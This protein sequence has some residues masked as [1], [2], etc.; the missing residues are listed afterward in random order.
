MYR[1]RETGSA[2][3]AVGLFLTA[4]LAGIAIALPPSAWAVDRSAVPTPLIVNGKEASIA[5]SPWQVAL[6]GPRFKGGPSKPSDRY[7]CTGSLLADDVVVTAAHC[8]AGY[9]KSR[10]GSL[11]VI[12]GR[13]WL[14][15]A[16][17][18]EVTRVR[19]AVFALGPDGKRRY[20]ESSGSAT[21]D[22]ALL[23]LENEVTAP[24]IRLAGDSEASVW[25]PGRKVRATG[26]GI[27]R[28]NTA[29]VSNRLR[30][31]G[32]VILPDSVCRRDNGSGYRPKTMV[33]LGGSAGNSSTCGGDSGGPLVART[34]AGPRLVGL[35][36]FGDFFCRG[37][38]PSVDTRVSGD[39]I[40]SWV[41]QKTIEISGVDPVGSTGVAGP[42]PD[43]CRVPGLVGRSRASART[44]LRKAGCKLGK[45]RRVARQG[46]GKRR[47]AGAFLPKG[48][49]APVGFRVRILLTR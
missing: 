35:T 6:V 12:S 43:Y 36:S 37:N 42:K 40:R 5:D 11:S 24:V 19:R 28:W 15:Q 9:T 39:A 34:S 3:M 8:L 23:K 44:A 18:G 31:A 47:V 7:F 14:D 13:T 20:R 41:R 1:S 30:A 17:T 27:T 2:G 22:V 49:L 10:I 29:R 38:V 33:C 32:Q 45:V 46:S 48:W 4:L 21:W 26:W 25:K 16:G